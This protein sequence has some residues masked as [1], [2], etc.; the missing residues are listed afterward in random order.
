MKLKFIAAA[1]LIAASAAGSA[2]AAIDSGGAG[3]GELFLT[4]WDSAN[5]Y[6]RD[7]NITLDAFTTALAAPTAFSSVFDLSTDSKFA[8]F[9]TG[10]DTATLQWNVTG[11]DNSGAR[12]VVETYAQTVTLPA[13]TKTADVIRTMSTGIAS[14]ATAVNTGIAAQGGDS[15]VFAAGVTGYANNSTGV[16]FGNNNGGLL[17]FVNT[18]SAAAN[19]YATGLNLMRIDGAASGVASTLYTPYADS[20]N[21][22][23][24]YLTTSGLTIAAVPEPETYAM[25]LAGLGLMGAIARRRRNQA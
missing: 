17:G 3:N 24:A 19:S 6:T 2:N 23:R 12:R 20:G 13:V 22:V 21:A 4:I 18:G 1:A 15:A 9:M 16:R 11:N 10:V 8:S 5:S 25:L 7:L 14:F